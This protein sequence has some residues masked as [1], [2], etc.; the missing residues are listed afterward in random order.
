M[1]VFTVMTQWEGKY[2]EDPVRDTAHPV[3]G[4]LAARDGRPVDRLACGCVVDC[5]RDGTTEK[6]TEPCGKCRLS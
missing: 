2:V 3:V 1:T 6:H 4:F 5:S